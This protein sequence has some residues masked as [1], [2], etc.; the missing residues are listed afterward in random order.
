MAL[1]VSILD[2][3]S[4]VLK[5]EGRFEQTPEESELVL[6]ADADKTGEEIP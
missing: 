3:R 4:L 6:P 1:T 5:I 2:Q